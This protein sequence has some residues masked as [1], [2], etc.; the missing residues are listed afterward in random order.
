MILVD[1]NVIIDVASADV[2]RAQRAAR[3][4]KAAAR[5]AIGPI[6]YAELAPGF[7][8]VAA[9]DS[10]LAA[11]DIDLLDMSRGGLFEAGMAFKSYRLRGGPRDKLL[12]DF[13]IGAQA[14]TEGC[15]LLTRDPARYR[16]SFPT[17][18][19]YEP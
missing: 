5:R 15:P 9:L 3:A 16:T 11:M 14:L 6:V 10:T 1:T 4:I 8:D 2:V 17:I 19:L 12:S 18:Q 7:A 13:L